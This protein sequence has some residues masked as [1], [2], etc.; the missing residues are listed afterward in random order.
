[1]RLQ[2]LAILASLML[3]AAVAPAS[4]FAED[5]T[6]VAAAASHECPHPDDEGP[7]GPACACL[8]CS[9]QVPS[10][11]CAGQGVHAPA[12]PVVG[13]CR[14]SADALEPQEV[15]SRIYYPPRA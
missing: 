5:E 4:V 14:P 8:C 7:C 3:F 1:M 13:Y 11:H 6:G 2:P 9:C 10:Q 12:R 15:H